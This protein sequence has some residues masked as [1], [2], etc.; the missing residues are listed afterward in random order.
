MMTQAY[1]KKKKIKKNEPLQN[2]CRK[3]ATKC[4]SPKVL[5]AEC[6]LEERWGRSCQAVLVIQEHHLKTLSSATSISSSLHRVR[7]GLVGIHT[8]AR[9]EHHIANLL[10]RWSHFSRQDR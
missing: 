6:M 1:E 7:T 3:L 4:S 10:W 2:T 8:L 9:Q 5:K